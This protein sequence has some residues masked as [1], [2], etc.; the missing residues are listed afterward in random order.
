[1]VREAPVVGPE[2]GLERVLELLRAR[3]DCPVMVLEGGSLVG[4]ITL[5]DI[6]ESIQAPRRTRGS[7][8]DADQSR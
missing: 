5:A 7:A 8:P 1:M 4:M 3:P 6:A 2:E